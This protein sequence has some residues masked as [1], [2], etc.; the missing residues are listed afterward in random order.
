M[1]AQKRRSLVR[2]EHAERIEKIESGLEAGFVC[3]TNDILGKS[4]ISGNQENWVAEY[5][6]C[7]L[8][9][10]VIEKLERAV[11]AP[12]WGLVRRQML[13]TYDQILAKV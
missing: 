6:H 2:T 9:K 5:T 7:S 10:E 8:D 1:E 3:L 12:T 11:S 13:T 4:K